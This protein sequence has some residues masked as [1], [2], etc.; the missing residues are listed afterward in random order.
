[1]ESIYCID[2]NG[3]NVLEIAKVIFFV[4]KLVDSK[5]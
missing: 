5:F 2:D 4:H 1:M 3:S